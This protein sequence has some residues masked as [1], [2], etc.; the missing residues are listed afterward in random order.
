[1]ASDIFIR[2]CSC[3]LATLASSFTLAFSPVHAQSVKPQL[4]RPSSTEPNS[5]PG[6]RQ[7]IRREQAP[8]PLDRV[9]QTPIEQFEPPFK[10]VSRDHWAYE[11]VTRLFYSGVV[12]GEATPAT[13]SN[14]SN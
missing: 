2:S 5:I 11:A 14:Q 10:D 8:L 7:L 3:L 1:M 13:K 12:K 4:D 9:Y 6:D